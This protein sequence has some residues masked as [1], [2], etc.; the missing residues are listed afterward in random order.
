MF[1]DMEGPHAPLVQ[2]RLPGMPGTCVACCATHALNGRGLHRFLSRVCM[3]TAGWLTPAMVCAAEVL[4][5]PH[6][7]AHAGTAG[8]AA[9]RTVAAAKGCA[10]LLAS[11]LCTAVHGAGTSIAS[12]GTVHAH[13]DKHVDMW[14]LE[15]SSIRVRCM[16]GCPSLPTAPAHGCSAGC[17]TSLHAARSSSC[18][19][20]ALPC[21]IPLL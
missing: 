1:W 17:S 14:C 6:D 18:E 21:S 15:H 12:I 13:G 10:A 19:A 7:R 5:L 9:S 16:R 2:D 4:L 11:P 8:A 20:G 3:S